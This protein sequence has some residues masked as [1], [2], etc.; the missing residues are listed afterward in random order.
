M[1]ALRAKTVFTDQRFTV[2]AVESVELRRGSTTHGRHLTAQLKPIA[3]VVKEPGRT[4]ALDME[5]Q[6]TSID[7][8]QLNSPRDEVS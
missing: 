1:A 4:Y 3:M 8:D 7:F 6:A 2:I 5:A